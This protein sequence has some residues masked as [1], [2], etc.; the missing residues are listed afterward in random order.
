MRRS[1]KF[2]YGEGKYYFTLKS[3]PSNI[4]MHRNTKEE[5]NM[6]YK[7]YVDLGKDVEWHGKWDGKKFIESGVPSV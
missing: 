1:K 5:A 2:D 3:S 6:T 4:T 7:K